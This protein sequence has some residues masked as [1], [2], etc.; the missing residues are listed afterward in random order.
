MKPILVH[1]HIFY[2][3]VWPE[4]R[5]CLLNIAPLPF[6]LYVTLVE[7][8][9]DI[10]ED[11]RTRF[12]GSVLE[13]VENRGYDVAP[14]LHILNRVNLDDYSYVVKLHTKREGDFIHFRDMR[15]CEWRNY[16]LT[17]LRTRERFQAHLAAFDADPRIG[18]Q[19]DYHVHVV[20]DV[21]GSKSTHRRLKEWL[22]AHKLPQMRF[23]YV[24]G[25]MFVARASLMKKLQAYGW[26][27]NDF[28]HAH[29]HDAQLA[30]VV[31]RLFGYFIHHQGYIVSDR[32]EFDAAARYLRRVRTKHILRRVGNFFYQAKLTQSGKKVIKILKIPVYRRMVRPEG[33]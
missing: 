13:L 27:M 18:M 17:F 9:E 6:D 7:K 4:L 25:S 32:C 5:D 23:C 19:A 26:K 31:E 2:P 22:C 28:P 21:Y 29:G 30:H 8:H 16:L 24:A 1:V 10:E 3:S 20:Q 12:P 33:A 15:G 11:I 14:F